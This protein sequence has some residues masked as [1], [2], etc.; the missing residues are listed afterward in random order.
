MPQR[1]AALCRAAG[2]LHNLM[3]TGSTATSQRRLLQEEIVGGVSERVETVRMSAISADNRPISTAGLPAS[4]LPSLAFALLA[5]R[6]CVFFAVFLARGRAF[7][8]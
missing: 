1:P 4:V 2:S 8:R 3:S 6:V 7:A 5:C